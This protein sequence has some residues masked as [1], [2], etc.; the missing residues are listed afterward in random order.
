MKCFPAIS[1][2][3]WAALPTSCHILLL[4]QSGNASRS[5]SSSGMFLNFAPT[6]LPGRMTPVLRVLVQRRCEAAGR[7][8]AG[9]T[10]FLQIPLGQ[11]HFSLVSLRRRKEKELLAVLENAS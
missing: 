10:P 7:R 2:N 9:I 11:R 8:K 6:L 1:H 5:C 3:V 4:W